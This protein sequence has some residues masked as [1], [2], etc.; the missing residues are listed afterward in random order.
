MNLIANVERLVKPACFIIGL[1]LVCMVGYVDYVT[2][3]EIAFSLFY[4]VPIVLVSWCTGWRL[5]AVTAVVC[6]EVWLMTDRL[7]GV[8]YSNQFIPVWNT[9]IRLTFFLITVLS[10]IQKKAL[11]LER[12]FARTDYC[13]GALNLRFF[14]DA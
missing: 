1:A 3:Y 2:G 7:S 5:G 10:L 9:L 14:R 8:V 6:V 11:D 12:S 4:L 13:T